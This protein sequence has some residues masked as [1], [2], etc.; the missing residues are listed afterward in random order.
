[1]SALN[2]DYLWEVLGLQGFTSGDDIVLPA[3]SGITQA[4]ASA[5]AKGQ[6][7]RVTVSIANAAIQLRSILENDNPQLVFIV[8]DTANTVQVFPHKAIGGGA[9][10]TGESMNGVANAAFNITANNSAIFVSSL[11]QP[12]RKGGGTGSTPALNWSAALLS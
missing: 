11:V 9:T 2:N 1:M 3:G 6:L 5:V 10:D 7:H 12:K 4:T 8:N